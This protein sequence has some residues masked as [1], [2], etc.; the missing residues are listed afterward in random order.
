[1]K[2]AQVSI[3]AFLLAAAMLAGFAACGRE[4]AE[5]AA[6]MTTEA[7]ITEQTRME[8]TTGQTTTEH[9]TEP[10]TAETG[11][12]TA[13]EENTNAEPAAAVPEGV[14]N[15]V[16]LSKADLVGWYNERINYVRDQRPRMTRTE[17]MKI[18]A[19]E[20]T[21]LGGAVDGIV[22]AAVKRF[23]PG[24]PAV[25]TIQKGTDNRDFF[26]GSMPGPVIRLAD[27]QSI[28]AKQEGGNYVVTLL[29][30]SE[31]NPKN[32]GVSKYS[33]IG[34][35]ATAQ[36]ILDTVSEMG[37]TGDID[38]ATLLYHDGKVVVTV[39]PKGEV[40][41]L[42]GEFYVDAQAREVRASILKTDLT[43]KQYAQHVFSGF[44][45]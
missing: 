6:L 1:M 41:R 10:A 7:A 14:P 34:S 3:L 15:P 39:N 38:K 30:G 35:P 33:R 18:L 5:P 28:T 45:Y 2:K 19:I 11:E 26:M 31:A 44:V 12:T 24:D 21:L 23:M 8:R 17:T 42:S 32:D 13:T 25:E 16:G 22:N 40:I 43:A 20:T 4:A 9:M 29:L 37:I 27:A 36:D